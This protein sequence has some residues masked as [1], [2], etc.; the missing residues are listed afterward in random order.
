MRKRLF[1]LALALVMLFMSIPMYVFA[2]E[3]LPIKNGVSRPEYIA[4]KVDQGNGHMRIGAY[5][6]V[7]DELLKLLSTDKYKETYGFNECR[8]FLQTD[9]SVDSD[10][11]WHY[12]K[13]WDNKV[14]PAPSSDRVT[15]KI[16]GDSEIFWLTY[17][18]N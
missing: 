1:F 7:P 18:D 16:V 10:K 15:N 2:L 11:N 3:E 8:V 13:D 12:N 4:Y 5:Y 9:W 14:N 6:I 17:E